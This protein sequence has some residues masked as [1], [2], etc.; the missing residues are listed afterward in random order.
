MGCGRAEIETEPDHSAHSMAVA[1]EA[2][3][4]MDDHMSLYQI[5]STWTD[6]WGESRPLRSLQGKPQVVAMTYTSCQVACPVIVADLRRIESSLDSLNSDAGILILS[7]DPD[8]D[9][10]EQMAAYVKK[11]GLSDRWTLMTA[12]DDQVRELAALLGVRYRRLQD[13]EYTHSNIISVLDERGV[14]VHRQ[15]GLGPDLVRSTVSF[16]TGR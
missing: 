5:E 3:T 16:I 4:A 8:R 10:P 15:E 12:P 13:G 1:P 9:T 11:Q 6:Q 7:L 14:L 2:D